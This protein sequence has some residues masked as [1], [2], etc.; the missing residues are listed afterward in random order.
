MATLHLL[1]CFNTTLVKVLCIPQSRISVS[2][3]CFNTT[4][5][6]VLCVWKLKAGYAISRFNTTLVKVLSVADEAP[7]SPVA[8]FQYNSC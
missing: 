4:L 8:E 2:P 5:V 6:K 1:R 7:Q 3:L